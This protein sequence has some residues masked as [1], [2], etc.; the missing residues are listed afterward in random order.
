MISPSTDLCW[1]IYPPK[2]PD[3][4]KCGLPKAFIVRTANNRR[5]ENEAKAKGDQV[6]EEEKNLFDGLRTLFRTNIEMPYEI[7]D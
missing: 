3:A 2:P 5:D 4:Y 1:I 6:F 7:E